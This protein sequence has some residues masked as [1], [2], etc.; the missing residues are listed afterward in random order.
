MTYESLL[1]MPLPKRVAI[2]AFAVL[3]VTGLL[4]MAAAAVIG[5]A[6]E[7][8]GTWL[9]ALLVAAAA[10]FVAWALSW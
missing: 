8:F 3:T 2:C 1:Q 5:F 4:P 10:A 9:I 7:A 6:M